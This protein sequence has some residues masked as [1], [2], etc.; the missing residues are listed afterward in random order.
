MPGTI[1]LTPSLKRPIHITCLHEITV[2]CMQREYGPA[3][4]SVQEC[5]AE[6]GTPPSQFRRLGIRPRLRIARD[7]STHRP[8]APY[9]PHESEPCRYWYE[10]NSS[11]SGLR[12]SKD[13]A[14]E[15]AP[16]SGLHLRSTHKALCKG[17]GPRRSSYL[18]NFPVR[19]LK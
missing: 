13:S 16:S 10:A 12:R 19:W 2:L 5:K 3:G 15:A 8:A 6:S 9:T 17:K 4:P 1:G 14:S 7:L 18:P 11:C